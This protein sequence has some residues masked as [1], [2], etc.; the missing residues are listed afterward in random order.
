MTAKTAAAKT[1]AAPAAA[2]LIAAIIAASAAANVSR[3][4]AGKV[5]ADP[6]GKLARPLTAAETAAVDSLAAIA[7]ANGD[8]G[9][10]LYSDSRDFY[11][12]KMGAV[13][14]APSLCNLAKS[15]QS[16]INN[17]LFNQCVYALLQRDGQVYYGDVVRLM[18]SF[19]VYVKSHP[20][21]VQRIVSITNVALKWEA[22]WLKTNG[23]ELPR[24]DETLFNQFVALASQMLG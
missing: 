18:V 11:S 16:T 6:W 17:A 7:A 20:L 1:P 10:K 3:R 5:A 8:K 21:I 4:G 24:M 15:S 9:W 2:D 13:P 22:G 14:C 19:G 23:Q 12:P